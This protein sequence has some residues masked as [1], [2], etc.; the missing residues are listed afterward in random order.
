MFF[1]VSSLQSLMKQSSLDDSMGDLD[2][3]GDD[4]ANS[5][6]LGATSGGHEGED[7]DT[8]GPG[9]L[10]TRGWG[11]MTGDSDWNPF[12]VIMWG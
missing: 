6:G 2:L 10:L 9:R 1:S 4:E 12:G 3:T 11:W 8:Q 7:L 5:S